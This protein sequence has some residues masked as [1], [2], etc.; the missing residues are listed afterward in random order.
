MVG[1][2]RG[3]DGGS[4]S[5][6]PRGAGASPSPA[7]PPSNQSSTG[8]K[9][10]SSQ[11]STGGKPTSSRPPAPRGSGAGEHEF[12]SSLESVSQGIQDPVAK[13]KFIRGSLDRYQALDLR[14]QKVPVRPLRRALYRW[15][16]LEGLRHLLT[17]NRMGGN[18]A[19]DRGLRLS[20]F[21]VRTVAV[22]TVA[23]IT[24]V[25]VLAAYKLSRVKDP[26]VPVVTAAPPAA[27]PA[28]LT[29][30]ANNLPPASFAQTGVTPSAIWLVEKDRDYEQYSNGLR[31]DTRYAVAGTPREFRTFSLTTGE[32]GPERHEPAGLLFHTSESDVWPLEAEFNEN[33]RDSSQRL[34][35]YVSRKKLYH[36]VIDR[37]GRVYRAVDEASKANHAGFSIW[38][39]GDEVHLNLNHSFL[40]VSFETRWEGGRALPITQAQ[41]AAGRNLSDHLRQKYDIA[42]AMCVTHGLTSVNPKKHLIGHHMDWARGFP[43]EAF[44]LPDQYERRSPSVELFGFGYDDDFT[45]IMGE[46]WPGV[47]DAEATLAREAANQGLTVLELQ[48]QRQ[49]LYDR[50]LAEQS[51]DDGERAQAKAR[52]AEPG[53]RTREQGVQGGRREGSAGASAR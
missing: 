35:K 51:R 30:T 26:G 49:D 41:F 27:A 13:L 25:A 47:R 15:L 11:S 7:K 5:S 4:R 43:F 39:R 53:G 46:P 42:S 3:R 38:S 34:L 50:W 18:V 6:P 40:G 17:A 21:G 1:Q 24:T 16:S 45:K 37:F 48:K 23:G 44:G 14:L 29:T 2:T 10:P 22:L 20:I 36:Y 9:P 31:I 28:P 8:G 32:R 12:L 52:P 19:L 33:L